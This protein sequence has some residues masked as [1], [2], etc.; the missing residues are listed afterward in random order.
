MKLTL[1]RGVRA[2]FGVTSSAQSGYD[3][4]RLLS[5]ADQMLYRA[6]HE[7]RNRVCVYSVEA[8]ESN[9][10]KRTPALTVV[11]T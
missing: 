9:K 3:L 2:R 1:T 6:K 4:S 8:A 5:H 11:N 7:G 10:A